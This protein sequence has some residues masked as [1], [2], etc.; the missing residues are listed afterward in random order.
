MRKYKIFLNVTTIKLR[1]YYSEAVSEIYLIYTIYITFEIVGMKILIAFTVTGAPNL[2]SIL[3][4]PAWKF[5]SLATSAVL[6]ARL[7]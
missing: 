7:V 3:R 1:V 2:I 4:V 5:A 6:Y